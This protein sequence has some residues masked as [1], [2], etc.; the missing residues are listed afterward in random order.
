[1]PGFD[2]YYG[3]G[4]IN[5]EALLLSHLDRTLQTIAKEEFTSKY[6]LKLKQLTEDYTNNL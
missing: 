5:P 2:P 3:F 4:L 6:I 1:M